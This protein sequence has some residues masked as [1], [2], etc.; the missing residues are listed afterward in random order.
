MGKIQISASK[1]FA[2]HFL[3]AAALAA[4][5]CLARDVSGLSLVSDPVQTLRLLLV[6]SNPACFL[7]FESFPVLIIL[8]CS[9]SKGRSL[10][11]STVG[12]VVTLTVAR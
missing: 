3:C 9:S 5:Y 10:L 7:Y 2:L 11:E 4:G 12:F 6:K 1:A 8:H